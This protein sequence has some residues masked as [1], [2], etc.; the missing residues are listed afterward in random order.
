MVDDLSRRSR[1]V[2]LHSQHHRLSCNF[3]ERKRSGLSCLYGFRIQGF[4]NVEASGKSAIYHL[5]VAAHVSHRTE[6]TSLVRK[7]LTL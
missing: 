5:A 7:D 1:R 3:P 6:V 2:G 4:A